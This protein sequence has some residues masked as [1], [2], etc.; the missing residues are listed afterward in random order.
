MA[1]RL[2]RVGSADDRHALEATASL[3][4]SPP[5]LFD[6]LALPG[7]ESGITE[8]AAQG[9]TIDFIVNQYRHGKTPAGA[10]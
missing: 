4:N 10:G 8:L 3:E 1:P 2:G 9:E 7:G 5:V 6:A